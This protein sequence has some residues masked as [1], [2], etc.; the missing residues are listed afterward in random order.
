MTALANVPTW[1]PPKVVRCSATTFALIYRNANSHVAVNFYSLD[2]ES[3]VAG[4]SL[5]VPFLLAAD[6]VQEYDFWIAACGLIDHPVPAVALAYAEEVGSDSYHVV[7]LVRSDAVVRSTSFGNVLTAHTLTDQSGGTQSAPLPHINSLRHFVASPGSSAWSVHWVG[8]TAHGSGGS[9]RGHIAA[10]R[11]Y[12]SLAP[13]DHE[14]GT[15]SDGYFAVRTE[16]VDSMATWDA[17]ASGTG[18]FATIRSTDVPHAMARF[19]L[20]PST[21]MYTQLGGNLVDL[22]QVHPLP[23]SHAAAIRSDGNYVEFDHTGLVATGT[24]GDLIEGWPAP[25]PSNV[26][27][28]GPS[29]VVYRDG[30][31]WHHGN[32]LTGPLTDLS[33]PVAPT[34]PQDAGLDTSS[35]LHL[36]GEVGVVLEL[37]NAEPD[38]TRLYLLHLNGSM[39]DPDPDP[40]PPVVTAV[41]PSEGSTAGG[42]AVVITG[43]GFTD[44]TAVEFGGGT[45]SFSVTSDTQIGAETPPHAVGAAAVTV[46]NAGGTSNND[47]L[48]NYIDPLSPIGSDLSG[49]TGH[50]RVNFVR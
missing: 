14:L 3:I 13:F 11:V 45:A 6:G 42:L 5:E 41:L 19:G 31:T 36:D 18:V 9:Y 22:D 29:Q 34:L 17:A 39:P 38:L 40:D 10:V 48:F 49:T 12:L 15:G 30:V 50:T 20:A 16:T 21:R 8:R 47:V 32:L 23:N 2:G 7:T 1:P 25:P 43:T 28:P 24:A 35:F 4:T 26:V 27:P 33:G 37:L 44:A 46:T